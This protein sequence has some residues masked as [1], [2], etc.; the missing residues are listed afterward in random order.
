[1]SG[2]AAEAPT[3]L[4]AAEAAI[5]AELDGLKS[6]RHAFIAPVLLGFIML[7]DSWDSIAIAYVMPSLMKE[8][9][10]GPA[11][12]GTLISSGYVGQF[13]G[14]ILLGTLAERFGRMPV[15][16]WAVLIMGVLALGCALTPDYNALLAIRFVQ[17]FAIG[18]ALPVA[19]AYINELAQ[20]QTRG[21]YF[22]IFQWI[23]MSGYAAASLSSAWII[24]N[25]GWR[26]LLGIGAIPLLLLPF[27]AAI[28]PESPRWLARVGRVEDANKAIRKLG[29]Q[30]AATAFSAAETAAFVA[31][32]IPISS[33]FAG[34]YNRRTITI[35][36]LWF[37]TAFTNFGLTTWSP[38]IYVTAFK[39]PLED[40]LRYSALRV[41]PARREE[42]GLSLRRPGAAL[43][44]PGAYAPIEAQRT[45]AHPAGDG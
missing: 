16:L 35:L 3:A 15:L 9:G 13:L 38:S 1:M 4:N 25:L 21:R 23:C 36:A 31:P 12:V 11:A 19:I 37:F 18:G 28:L 8:W 7:F 10:L 26:W 24:P 5:G 14:A 27:V 41:A 32:K 42:G 40:A 34:N 33:L 39:L 2:H 6:F 43:P 22:A 20:T 29:G 17:G 30:G 44:V 45:P